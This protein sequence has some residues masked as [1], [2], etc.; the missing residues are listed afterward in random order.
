MDSL[1]AFGGTL[2][3]TASTAWRETGRFFQE[4]RL[5]LAVTGLSGAGKTVFLTSLVANLLALGQGRNS[6]PVLNQALGGRLRQVRLE[7]AGEQAMPW[8]DATGNLARLAEGGTAPWPQGTDALSSLSLSLTIERRGKLALLGPRRVRLELVD[9]PG[10]WLLDL[11]LMEKSFAEFSREAAARLQAAPAHP[12]SEAFQRFLMALPANARADDATAR[13][14]AA[15]YRAALTGLRDERGWRL[16][17][18]GHFLQPGGL[19]DAPLLWFFPFPQGRATP[20]SLAAA[21]ARRY[22]AWRARM[23]V[24]LFEPFLARADLQVVLVDVLGAICAGQGAF[25][26][27]RAAL[28][29]MGEALTTAR[30]PFRNGPGRIAFVASKADHVPA[31]LRPA[32]VDLLRRMVAAP[33]R[34][35]SALHY[36]AVAAL[37]CTEDGTRTARISLPG[38]AAPREMERPVVL[39]VPL[40]ETQRRPFDPGTIPSTP[41]GRDDPFWARPLFTL[42]V[43]QPPA[44]DGHGRDGMPQLGMDKLLAWLLEEEV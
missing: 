26:D 16:L 7:P 11:P 17:Q 1:S 23:R 25:E 29:L 44:L 8:F 43:F 15:L 22:D 2:R 24:E 42:P 34:G 27:T 20:G 5:R 35:R 12:A 40:G 28:H 19:T 37:R 38:D 30:G 32:L 6:L 18:P 13:H 33:E 39:G 9:Y 14:G 21:M 4:E 3:D 10:E 31:I 36:E 41:P